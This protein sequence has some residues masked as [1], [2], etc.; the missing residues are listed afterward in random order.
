MMSAL[1]IAKA[2]LFGQ[3]MV[4]TALVCA[5]LHAA[6]H[7]CKSADGKTAYSDQ[8]CA[9][10]QE[11][12]T[13]KLNNTSPSAATASTSSPSVQSLQNKALREKINAALTPECRALGDRASRSLQSDSDVSLD[14]VKRA[15]GEFETR[16]GAQ[17]AEATRQAQSHGTPRLDPYAC[18]RLREALE[19]DR[20]RNRS[21]TNQEIIAMV[22][23]EH[24]IDNACR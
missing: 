16:C 4:L 22:K 1:T 6:V 2:R 7:L 18:Q 13:L 8:P 15:V 23:R 11:G 24:E 9:G 5:P 3:S 14:V 21:K 12:T 20:S 17:L 19:A 10:G